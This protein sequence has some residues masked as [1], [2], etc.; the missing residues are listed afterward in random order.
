VDADAATN[1]S[2][3]LLL[4]ITRRITVSSIHFPSSGSWPTGRGCR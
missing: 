4:Q 3:F 1:E 2:S